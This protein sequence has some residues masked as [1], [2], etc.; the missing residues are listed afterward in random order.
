M[1]PTGFLLDQVPMRLKSFKS[2]VWFS[3]V[4]SLAVMLLYWYKFS[5]IPEITN[6]N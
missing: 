1:R 3:G 5:S 6:S 2:L 4:F